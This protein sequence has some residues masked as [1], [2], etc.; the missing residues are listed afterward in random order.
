LHE[1]I[2]EKDWLHVLLIRGEDLKAK[3]PAAGKR[4][5]L[6]AVFLNPPEKEMWRQEGK[7]LVQYVWR[8]SAVQLQSD[9]AVAN[10]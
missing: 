3:E 6:L 10:T 7:R 1:T 9:L 8:C 4:S 2:T 5:R